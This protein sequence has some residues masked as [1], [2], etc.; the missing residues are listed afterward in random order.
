[1]AQNV[2]LFPSPFAHLPLRILVPYPPHL[3]YEYPRVW[4]RRRPDN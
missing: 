1:M 4:P 2:R 3:A